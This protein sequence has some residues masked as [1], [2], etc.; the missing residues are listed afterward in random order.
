[1]SN[2]AHKFLLRVIPFVLGVLFVGAPKLFAAPT[3][4]PP[5][6]KWERNGWINYSPYSVASE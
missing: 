1:M 6:Y 5:L 2:L 4:P 3:P